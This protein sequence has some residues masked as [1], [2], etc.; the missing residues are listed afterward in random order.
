MEGFRNNNIKIYHHWEEWLD[1]IL[2]L[3]KPSIIIMEG[4]SN[5]N[6]KIYHHWEEWLDI[7]WVNVFFNNYYSCMLD[8]MCH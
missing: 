5:N 4:F 1:I 3:L 2:L 7:A 6:I 8:L